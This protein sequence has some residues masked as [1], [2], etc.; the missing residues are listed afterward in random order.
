MNSI[1]RLAY[2]LVITTVFMACKATVEGEQSK[3]NSAKNDI[4]ELSA[5]FPRYAPVVESY[6]TELDAKWEKAMEIGDEKAKIQAL[7]SVNSIVRKNKVKPLYDLDAQ[8]EVIEGDIAFL[9]GRSADEVE[10]VILK[11][12]DDANS[13]L[14]EVNSTLGGSAIADPS[15]AV[16]EINGYISQ[17]KEADKYMA[18]AVKKLKDKDEALEQAEKEAAEA[19]KA[20]EVS[21]TT[22]SQA[23]TVSTK[24]EVK[25]VKCKYCKAS[26]KATA[27]KCSG[28]GAA[29]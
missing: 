22:Q 17:I 8:L 11:E 15:Q 1:K 6:I 10:I 28:C 4:L 2:L 16:I 25:M 19:A 9:Q 14:A 5:E 27:T 3:F 18:M 29:L 7:K 26:S 24:E 13:L 12:I 20:Q 21:S 23:T